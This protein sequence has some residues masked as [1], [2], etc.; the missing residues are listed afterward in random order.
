MKAA[1]VGPKL[2]PNLLLFASP[3]GFF[4]LP[5][6]RLFF[7]PSIYLFPCQL[8]TAAGPHTLL[9]LFRFP[10]FTL[11]RCVCAAARCFSVFLP[12]LPAVLQF[13]RNQMSASDCLYGSFTAWRV[14]RYRPLSDGRGYCAGLRCRAD[15]VKDSSKHSAVNSRIGNPRPGWKPGT[16]PAASHLGRNSCSPYEEDFL[17]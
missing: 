10:T 2:S 13:G 6:L 16:R 4:S 11:A 12:F 3:V 17:D 14:G 1:A 7:Y 15:L 5:I 8:P 9:S